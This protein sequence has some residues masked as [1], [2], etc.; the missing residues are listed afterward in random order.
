MGRSELKCHLDSLADPFETEASLHV[1]RLSIKSEG[2][3][4]VSDATW[5]VGWRSKADA[6]P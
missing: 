1:D 2:G 5:F 4:T 6:H 3:V